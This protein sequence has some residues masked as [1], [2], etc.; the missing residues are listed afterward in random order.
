MTPAKV[1]S[2]ELIETLRIYRIFLI[3]KLQGKH[4]YWRPVPVTLKEMPCYFIKVCLYQE[5]F[6]KNIETSFG[7]GI[8]Q[9]MRLVIF[10]I[11]A[12]YFFSWVL[13]SAVFEHDKHVM[14][15]KW[16]IFVLKASMMMKKKAKI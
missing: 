10:K 16:R 6:Q 4:L 2:G 11:K 14:I 1:F 7:T 15:T 9:T 13:C 3:G 8:Q 5:H 12:L